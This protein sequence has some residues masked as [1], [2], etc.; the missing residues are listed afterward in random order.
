MWPQLHA[1]FF[2][3]HPCSD[4]AP[5]TTHARTDSNLWFKGATNLM[6]TTELVSATSQKKLGI[7]GLKYINNYIYIHIYMHTYI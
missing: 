2:D 6:G 7:I 4:F 3:W 1:L 5:D